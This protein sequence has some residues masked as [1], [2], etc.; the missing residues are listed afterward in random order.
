MNRVIAIAV[1]SY[2]TTPDPCDMV[3]TDIARSFD[4]NEPISNIIKW[5][6]EKDAI[7]DTLK[8]RIDES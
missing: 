3:K 5:A 7:L 2:Y 8:I 6:K 1:T 4:I